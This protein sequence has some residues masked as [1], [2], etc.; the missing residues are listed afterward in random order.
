MSVAATP[1][2][3]PNHLRKPYIQPDKREKKAMTIG[4]GFECMA[5]VILGADRQMTAAGHHKFF[6]RKIFRSLTDECALALV[7]A[8]DLSLANEVA[9][10][11]QTS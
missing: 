7:G 11:T 1:V 9:K 2:R 3:L 10:A 4:I 6:E 8:N 5:G